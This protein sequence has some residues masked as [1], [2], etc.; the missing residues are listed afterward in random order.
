MAAGLIRQHADHSAADYGF[1]HEQ[2]RA[3]AVGR[4]STPQRRAVHTAI[5]D[6]L[7]A[8]GDPPAASLPLIA[9][10]AKNDEKVACLVLFQPKPED[11]G[12]DVK[13]DIQTLEGLPT[14][15]VAM[16]N[17]EAERMVLE[18]NSLAGDN[19]PIQLLAS[20]PKNASL[21]LDDKKIQANVASWIGDVTA[22]KKGQTK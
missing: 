4:L 12:F 5:V 15:V 14:C 8:R 2:V 22:P 6:M 7:M 20:T 18:A 10:H 11:Y 17:D 13:A 1:T 9:R 3:F 19:P 21:L 16:K